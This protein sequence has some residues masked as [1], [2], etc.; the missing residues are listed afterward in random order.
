MKRWFERIKGIFI[1]D[2]ALTW[3]A[4]LGL[5][6]LFGVLGAVAAVYCADD[7]IN[8]FVDNGII[9][10]DNHI[11]SSAVTLGLFGVIFGLGNWLIKNH[12]VRK[13]FKDTFIGQNELI[14]SNAVRAL[15]D[16]SSADENT[17]KSFVD[18]KAINTYGLREI[19]RLALG[20]L[21]KKER[22]DA[23]TAAGLDLNG[24]NLSNTVLK[25]LNL[26]SA[27]LSGASLIGAD[28][29]GAILV[30][31]NLQ[32]TSLHYANLQE[33]DLRGANLQAAYL[34]GANLELTDLTETILYGADLNS[35]DLNRT[36]LAGA[37]YN[38]N[39]CFPRDFD[40][41][42]HGLIKM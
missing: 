16:K 26:R 6:L 19:A 40:P 8:L 24:A 13:Q 17:E 28:L 1:K 25:G 37:F 4:R 7:V 9:K 11:F 23:V 12:D 30:N 36:I 29:H 5:L 27:R 32:E 34:D 15:F 38:G 20:D 2:D 3:W 41:V 33:A 42:K 35:V 18:R 10:E 22:I 21:I 39:T 31:A 14:F